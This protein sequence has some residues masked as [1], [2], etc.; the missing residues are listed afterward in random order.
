MQLL[1]HW[2]PPVESH[3]CVAVMA[4]SYSQGPTLDK[5]LR[6]GRLGLRFTRVV[7]AQL[8]DAMAYLHSR[9]VVHRDCKPDNLIVTGATFDQDDIWNDDTTT[10]VDSTDPINN[11]NNNPAKDEWRR[12]RQLWHVTLVDFGFARALTPKDLK[13]S[14]PVQTPTSK[15]NSDAV[16]LDSSA[17]R[18]REYLNRSISRRF[19]RR[20][21]ALG[22]RTFTAP[23]V[24]QSI[25]DRPVP[26][27][28]RHFMDITDTLSTHVSYYGL[29]A[30][31]FSVGCT[32]KYM[33]TGVL[34]TENV[35]D[36]IALQNTPLAVLCR[37]L[38]GAASSKRE[39][40]V[41]YRKISAIPKEVLRLIQGLTNPD[42]RQRTTVR[43]A[44][45]YPWIN[46]VLED[47][48]AMN[49]TIFFLNFDPS[50]AV[51]CQPQNEI[52]AAGLDA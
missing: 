17:K 41:Q 11:N 4:L 12:L 32:I 27:S 3:T 18:K 45:A 49:N 31:A 24:I 35:N 14:P 10:G 26:N 15:S 21:S 13:V 50:D 6:Y 48:P 16:A 51:N 9:A 52:A 5:L 34:P 44:L 40:P 47:S 42:P 1:G 7:A 38:C 46:E 2:E 36:V 29:M 22:T 30:D 43:H 23:E 37:F 33:L 8:V 28:S 20:M 19:D 39:R 25:Q